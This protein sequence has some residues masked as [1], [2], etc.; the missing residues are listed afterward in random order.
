MQA[1][2]V[3]NDNRVIRTNNQ[4]SA[5][6]F[7]SRLYVNNGETATLICRKHKTQTGAIRWAQKILVSPTV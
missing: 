7:E 5:G 6:Q 1:I 4:N 2:H 3:K